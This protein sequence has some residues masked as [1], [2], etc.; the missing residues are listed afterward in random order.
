MWDLRSGRGRLVGR[1]DTVMRKIALAPDGRSAATAGIDNRIRLW[2]LETGMVTELGGHD[3]LVGDLFFLPGGEIVSSGADGMVLLWRDRT[4]REVLGRHQG[5]VQHIEASGDGKT[6]ASLGEDGVVRVWRP[7]EHG[8]IAELRGPAGALGR[9]A[10]SPDGARVAAVGAP[11]DVW[12]W[13]VASGKGRPL[14]GHDKEVYAASFSRDGRRLATAGADHTIRL[15]DVETGRSEVLRDHRDA[16]D[17]VRFARESDLLF[18]SAQDGTA[19]VWMLAER[20]AS[21]VQVLGGHDRDKRMD[22]SADGSVVVTGAGSLLSRW[23][24]GAVTGTLRG[25]RGKVTQVEFAR[26]GAVLSG[27]SDWTVRL[28]PQGRRAGEPRVMRGHEAA[29]VSL[30]VSADGRFAA[31]VDRHRSIWLWDLAGS[32]PEVTGRK[33]GGRA[34]GEARFTPD[35]GVV[36]APAVEHT[37]RLWSTATGEARLLRGHTSWVTAVALSPDGR[38]LASASAD[39]TVRLWDFASGGGR[40][41]VGHEAVVRFVEFAGSGHVVSSD[42]AGGVREWDVATG[43]GRELGRGQIGIGALAVTAGGDLVAWADGEGDVHLWSRRSGRSRRLARRETSIVQL[44]FAP[45]GRTL[46][47][48]DIGNRVLLWDTATAASLVLPGHGRTISDFAISPAG[49]MVATADSDRSV[50]LW[51]Y[52]LPYEPDSLRAWLVTVA[53]P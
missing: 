12:L 20:S 37:V 29:I 23:K 51:P 17:W 15:W 38:T 22:V 19:R 39:R 49:L 33:L 2:S 14:V 44:S 41:L 53:G 40:A 32:A 8:P 1:Q 4:G 42:L 30:A 36:V 35:G 25:H 34:M 10:I 3:G 48:R 24:I 7:G 11:G 16:V 47:G 26:D 28:W 46:L 27:G 52:D 21:A 31:S 5:P 50:R 13:Q 45:D 6:L 43:A 18:S 9:V